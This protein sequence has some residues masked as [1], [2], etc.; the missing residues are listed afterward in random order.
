[1]MSNKQPERDSSVT[2]VGCDVKSCVFHD[3]PGGYCTA[4]K[5]NVQSGKALVKS[6]TFCDTF[7]PKGSF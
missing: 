1:M 7:L 2:S 5:I 3:A 6:E 4:K